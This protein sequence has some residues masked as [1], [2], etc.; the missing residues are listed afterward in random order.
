[1]SVPARTTNS[2]KPYVITWSVVT[3]VPR[4][5]YGWSDE[6]AR[7]GAVVIDWAPK[8]RSAMGGSATD[9]PMVTTIF[10]SVDRLRT[11]RNSTA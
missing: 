4:K 6:R 2:T 7:P 10:T 3:G 11:N 8:M 9:S 1:M 5:W